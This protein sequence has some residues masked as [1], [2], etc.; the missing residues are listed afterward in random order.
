MADKKVVPVEEMVQK[1]RAACAA[2]KSHD[3][4]ILAR[5]D[6]RQPDGLDEAIRSPAITRLHGLNYMRRPEER[7]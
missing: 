3:F 6:A 7:S 5:T 1:V 4:F 2:R